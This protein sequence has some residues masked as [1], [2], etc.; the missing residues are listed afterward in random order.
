MLRQVHCKTL[1]SSIPSTLL[2][3]LRGSRGFRGFRGYRGISSLTRKR[4]Q[5]HPRIGHKDRL[6][7]LVYRMVPLSLLVY[8]MVRLSLPLIRQKV[9]HSL[10]LLLFLCNHPKDHHSFPMG[11]SPAPPTRP[12]PLSQTIWLFPLKSAPLALSPYPIYLSRGQ[13]FTPV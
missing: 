3:S 6:F 4:L 2:Q 7:L 12:L 11:P 1:H 13:K 5:S 9:P 10:S 8:C